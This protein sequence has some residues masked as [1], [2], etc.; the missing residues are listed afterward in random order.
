[1]PAEQHDPPSGAACGARGGGPD[2]DGLGGVLR[3]HRLAAGLSLRQLAE[4]CGCAKSYLWAIENGTK[5]PPSEDMLRRIEA[6]LAINDGR[7]VRLGAWGRVPGPVRD[8]LSRSHS[9]ASA[10]KRL[11]EILA[12]GLDERGRPRGSLDAAYRSGEF[13]RL[14][15]QI[16]PGA[17]GPDPV[18]LPFEVPLINKVS[19]GYPQG[20]TDMGYPAR[21]ADEYVRCPDLHDADAFAARVVGDSMSPDYR[22]GDIV[23]FSPA[24]PIV[25]G[26]DCF[27]RLAPDDETTFKRV[28][29]ECG[30]KAERIRLQPINSRYAP[31]VLGREDVAGLYR[32]VKVM[33]NV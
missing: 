18:D 9:Q 29:F 31:R 3:A 26:D 13:Q 32:A 10:V 27:A 23:I 2:G 7:L 11:G 19:A 5:G 14:V 20:F 21:V 6:A 30:D 4:R 28:Y 22:E 24:M 12:G 25:D 33:R 1:M 8:D 16:E 17:H 15:S